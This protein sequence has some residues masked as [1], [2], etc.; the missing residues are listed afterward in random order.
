MGRKRVS[1]AESVWH[2]RLARHKD[3]GLTV[4]E[5]C[6]REGVSGPSFYQ[7]RKRLQPGER[8]PQQ[9]ETQDRVTTDGKQPSRF[10]PVSVS[11]LNTA[12]IELPN[13][14]AVRLP[15]TNAEALQTAILAAGSIAGET[16]P[17]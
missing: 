12:E 6:R 8:R 2:E 17:C 5:F 7:W 13:G 4:A 1:G 9:R 11:A 10:V 3:S 15:L 14:V 16:R